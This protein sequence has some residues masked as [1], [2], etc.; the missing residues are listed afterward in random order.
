[1]LPLL[2]LLQL[3]LAVLPPLA[4]AVASIVFHLYCAVA[5]YPAVACLPCFVCKPGRS[6]LHPDPPPDP[7]PGPDP[8]AGAY[9]KYKV[10]A[11]LLLTAAVAAATV[12][13]P[14]ARL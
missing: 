7:N 10:P 11:A 14:Q 8:S 3:W 13:R 5:A 4:L 6:W 2:L 1:M 12:L 9:K